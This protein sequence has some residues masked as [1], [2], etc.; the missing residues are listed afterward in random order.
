[1]SKNIG[2]FETKNFEN[3]VVQLASKHKEDFA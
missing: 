1:M 3:H 2:Q